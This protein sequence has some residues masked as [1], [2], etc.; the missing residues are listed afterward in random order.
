MIRTTVYQALQG[1]ASHR[2]RIVSTVLLVSIIAS[3]LCVVLESMDQ[4][5]ALYAVPINMVNLIAVSVFIVEYLL[6]V[7][8]CIED[9]RYKHP[10][11]GR[12]RF[13]MSP[14]MII[15]ALAIL[16]SFLVGIGIDLRSLRLFR[17]FRLFR[18]LKMARYVSALDTMKN[19]LHQKK[20]Q[21][22][23]T[24]G[25]LFF[26][27][28]I[29]SSLMYEL[30]HE[31]QPQSFSSIPATMWWAVASL[32]TVGYGDIYPITPLGKLLAAVTAI[33]G[34]GLVALPAG[35]LASGFSSEVSQATKPVCPKC[36]EETK[37]ASSE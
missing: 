17:S 11:I 23:M 29:T 1:A 19:V 33:L 13:I 18:V 9:P 35:I 37:T 6:R 34:V 4:V 27:L 21:L 24:V 7:W 5:M 25:I 2:G 8:T 31:T 26:M 22:V 12:L 28:L 3:V 20:H 15:D 32:T 16:P 10:L 36:G 30:E 14:M